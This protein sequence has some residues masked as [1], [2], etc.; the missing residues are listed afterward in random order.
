LTKGVSDRADQ[1]DKYSWEVT[2]R[3]ATWTTYEEKGL[4]RQDVRSKR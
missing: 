2:I 3:A 4:E 1:S